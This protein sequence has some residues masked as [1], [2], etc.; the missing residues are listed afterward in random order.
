MAG[1][2]A[3][4]IIALPGRSGIAEVRGQIAEVKIK[5]PPE[6]VIWRFSLLQ[7]DL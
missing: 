6:A 1:I 4:E 5:S 7:S 3:D 2:E